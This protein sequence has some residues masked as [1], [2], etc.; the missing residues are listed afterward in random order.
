MNSFLLHKNH[1]AL[2][3][4]QCVEQYTVLDFVVEQLRDTEAVVKHMLHKYKFPGTS[5]PSCKKQSASD[6]KLI[7][8]LQTP[9]STYQSEQITLC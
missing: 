2:N 8:L 3:N 7:S 5:N 1:N 9:E 6:W 4:S